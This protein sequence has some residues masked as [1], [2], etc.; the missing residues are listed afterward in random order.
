[1]TSSYSKLGINMSYPMSVNLYKGIGCQNWNLDFLSLPPK[2]QYFLLYAQ[3]S[4]YVKTVKHTGRYKHCHRGRKYATTTTQFGQNPCV[5]SALKS[6]NQN[7]RA[8]FRR[9]TSW[10]HPT[11]STN[12]QN[13]RIII[14]SLVWHCNMSGQ[15]T[16]HSSSTAIMA[17][18]DSTAKK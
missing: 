10:L 1:M 8:A 17:Y 7:C 4:T 14:L 13:Y 16:R 12:T 2:C 15:R 9:I 3:Q 5:C 11:L 18:V 6:V